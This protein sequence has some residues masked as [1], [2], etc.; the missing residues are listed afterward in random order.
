MSLAPASAPGHARARVLVVEDEIF[1][2]LDVS[3]ALRTAGFEVIEA[4]SADDAVG[5]MEAG[6]PVDVVFTDVQLPG[7]LDGLDLANMMR[8]THPSLVVVITSGNLTKGAEANRIG[9]LF[10][11]K[12]YQIGDVVDLI[13]DI[14]ETGRR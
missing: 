11:P 14:A 1:I 2:R 9:R 5:F 8:A 12:P 10:V 7:L 4:E 13:A 3:E 6:E